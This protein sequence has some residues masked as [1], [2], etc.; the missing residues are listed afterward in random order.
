MSNIIKLTKEQALSLICPT[1]YI[2]TFRPTNVGLFG[3]DRA[4]KDIEEIL[5]NAIIIQIAGERAININHG[6]AVIYEKKGEE[7]L[8][9]LESVGDKLKLFLNQTH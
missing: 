4:R 3:C 7:V 9:F 2:H 8:L 1:E 5:E 6:V